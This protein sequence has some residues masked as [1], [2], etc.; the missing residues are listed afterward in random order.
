MESF[1]P[2][3][4][5]IR[6]QTARM[7]EIYALLQS[8]LKENGNLSLSESDRTQLHRAIATI[9]SNMRQLQAYIVAR[10]EETS[11]SHGETRELEEILEAVLKWQMERENGG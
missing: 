6:V 11:S 1:L 7:M 3:L 10:Q 9:E 4:A 8:E 5:R 2:E